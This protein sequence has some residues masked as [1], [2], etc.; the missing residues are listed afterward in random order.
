MTGK[1]RFEYLKKKSHE[2]EALKQQWKEDLKKGNVTEELRFVTSMVKK[3]V[4]R[5]DRTHSYYRGKEDNKRV[6]SLF[7]LLCTYAL[8]HPDVSYC[9][10]MSDMASVLL[11]VQ[12]DEA[13]AYLCLCS[14]MR[15][16]K[17]N[18]MYDGKAMECK[19]DHLKLLLRHYDQEFYS[20]LQKHE[21]DDLFFSYRWIL[22]ELK[23]EFP[24]DDALFMLEVMWSTLPVDPPIMDLALSEVPAPSPISMSVKTPTGSS[25]GTSFGTPTPYAKLMALRR[26]SSQK[27]LSSL[28]TNSMQ[29]I[30][31]SPL[32]EDSLDG[33]TDSE[34]TQLVTSIS[35]NIA[36][37][38]AEIDK[39]LLSPTDDEVETSAE[40]ALFS[41]HNI[42]H[43]QSE[44]TLSS[45]DAIPI[46]TRHQSETPRDSDRGSKFYLGLQYSSNGSPFYVY[47]ERDREF[48]TDAITQSAPTGSISSLDS[49]IR[50]RP[51]TPSKS[52]VVSAELQFAFESSGSHTCNHR[53]PIFPRPEDFGYG[54]P[55]LMFATATMILQHRDHIMH[56]RMD[57]DDIVTL[58]DKSVRKNDVNKILYRAKALYQDYLKIDQSHHD[59]S[60]SDFDLSVSI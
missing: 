3:D 4:I 37:K 28:V 60:S 55:F 44:V 25:S 24:F 51:V 36:D 23:R 53:P 10:G 45:C 20:Y 29:T 18:F 57:F 31:P 50:S 35:L 2:Y 48:E 58:F 12:A 49:G 26:N 14:L 59:C 27:M 8:N 32:E 38:A 22:L 52:S 21:V 34:G 1:Q 56:S 15:R 7:D 33:S 46:R 16:L 43:T 9:Q 47:N 41:D 40:S 6:L 19:F 42:G 13:N 17:H 11:V 54:N 30:S 5:T 39:S